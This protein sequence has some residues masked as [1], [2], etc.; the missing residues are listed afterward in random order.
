MHN[1][2]PHF[3]CVD[4]RLP[5]Q[6]AGAALTQNYYSTRHYHPILDTSYSLASYWSMA[7]FVTFLQTKRFDEQYSTN[8]YNNQIIYD[9]VFEEGDIYCRTFL[10]GWIQRKKKTL[11]QN[12][13]ATWGKPK[14]SCM[15]DVW[16]NVHVTSD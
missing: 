15:V 7:I 4:H 3:I 5:L 11:P 9:N 2:F 10:F 13:L 8:G 1:M 14:L 16:L 12:W 6:S